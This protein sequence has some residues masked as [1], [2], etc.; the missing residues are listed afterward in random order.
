MNKMKRAIG[1][2]AMALGGGLIALWIHGQFTVAPTSSTSNL[3]AQ[4]VRYVNLPGPGGT[5]TMA[6]DFTEAAERTVNAVVHVTTETMVSQEDPFQ[7]FFWGYRSP[8][9]PRPQQGAGS[10]VIISDDGYIVTNNHVVE[11]ADKIRVHLNDK[12]MLDARVI[13]RDP[14]TDIALLKVDASDLPFMPY[15]NSD[16]VKVGEWVLAV[17]NPFNLT[18]T[19]TAGIVSAKARSINI[20]RGD[21]SREIFPIE[22]FIQTDAAVNPG[23][24]GG[25]LVNAAGELIGINTAIASQTGSYA[26]YSFA[27]PVN[28]AKKVTGDLLEFG[29]VQRAY[30]GVSIMDMDQTLAKEVGMDRIRGVYVRGLTA[31]GAAAASGIREGDVILKVGNLNVDN[32][33]ALQEQ[34]GKFRPGNSVAVTLWRDGAERTLDLELR[35]RDGSTTLTTLKTPASSTLLGAELK[36]ATS[37]ELRALQ[38]AN[39]V[40]VTAI[41]GGRFRSSGIKEGFII[42]SIDQQPVTKPEDIARVLDNK[43]GGVLIEGVYPNGVKAYYGLGV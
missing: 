8:Q 21:E 30:I 2:F 35:G 3:P 10:G 1:Y 32:V 43:R 4:A 41:N 11:G 27:V 39:G 6:V 13:G 9:Q 16:D 33:P 42:T 18:S 38:L 22:S 5:A 19:V 15:G 31:D 40:K 20:L 14:S 34:V 23:N 24:S 28:I 7:Q 17:G 29:S 25:A 26:G 37:E 36:A 12:R